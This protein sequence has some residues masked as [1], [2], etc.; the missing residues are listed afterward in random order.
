MS[1]LKEHVKSSGPLAVAVDALEALISDD[2]DGAHGDRKK[3][4][5]AD[6]VSMDLKKIIEM[7]PGE[8]IR[9]IKDIHKDIEDKFNAA[10]E[11]FGMLGNILGAKP[12]MPVSEPPPTR[13]QV[14]D[15]Q[16]RLD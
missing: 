9:N 2:T 11:T 7:P 16:R 14:A 8:H 5:I 1:L 6:V 4:G 13:D 15:E 10:K 3:F 12:S